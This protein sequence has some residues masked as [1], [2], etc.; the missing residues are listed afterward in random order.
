[1]TPWPGT[2]DLTLV[3]WLALDAPPWLVWA[4]IIGIVMVAAGFVIWFGLLL[5]RAARSH[6]DRTGGAA[7]APPS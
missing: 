5:W 7:H 3:Y 4:I 6:D 1:M 2:P